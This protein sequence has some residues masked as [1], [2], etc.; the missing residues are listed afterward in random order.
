MHEEQRDGEENRERKIRLKADA[1]GE[2]LARQSITA[3][4]TKREVFPTRNVFLVGVCSWEL[5]PNTGKGEGRKQIRAGQ[6]K[7]IKHT[8][9][10]KRKTP[11]GEKDQKQPEDPRVWRERPDDSV[12][13]HSSWEAGDSWLPGADSTVCCTRQGAERR[14]RAPAGRRTRCQP[15]G[16]QGRCETAT[17]RS[18]S[19]RKESADPTLLI[20]KM[21]LNPGENPTESRVLMLY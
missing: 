6:L 1:L 5:K 7:A 17:V 14:A 8:K 19:I 21:L 15:A 2:E 9:L 13:D 16:T 4:A 12:W 18:T 20:L 10:M 3:T 11:S